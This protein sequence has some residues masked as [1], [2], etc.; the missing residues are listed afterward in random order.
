[1]VMISACQREDETFSGGVAYEHVEEQCALGPRLVGSEASRQAA[2]NVASQLRKNGWS[3]VFQDFQY[4]GV[5]L[6]NVVGKRGRGPLVVLGAHY[7]TR[8][9]AD[10]DQVDRTQPVLGANDGASGVAVLLELARVLDPRRIN[11]EVWLAFFDAEDQG[12][13]NG[14]PYAVGAAYMAD[15]MRLQP[16][17]VVIVDMVGDA[18]QDIYWEGNSDPGLRRELWAI[19][20]EL[21]YGGFFIP[22]QKHT[23]IDDHVPFGVRG[24]ASV[25][26]IDFD[27][28]HWHTAQDT[29]DKVTATSLER[30]GRVLEEW[31]ERGGC[32]ARSGVERGAEDAQ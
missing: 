20:D 28:H 29:P 5:S 1:M 7:D 26:I 21:G 27:Y 13:I 22:Q 25:D 11:C 32:N 17:A 23:V 18:E 3:V 9:L 31:L 8:A 10:R 12:G 15:S 2:D 4:G 24:W 6:R 16:E 19:A 14:W 30:V